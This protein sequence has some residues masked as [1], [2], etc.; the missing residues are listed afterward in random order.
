MDSLLPMFGGHWSADVKYE[1]IVGDTGRWSRRLALARM[2]D[3]FGSRNFTL[4]LRIKSLGKF[5]DAPRSDAR[6]ERPGQG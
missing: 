4:S 2:A 3:G 5:T 6:Q 1:L